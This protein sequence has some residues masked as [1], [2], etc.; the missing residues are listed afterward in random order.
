MPDALAIRDLHVQ[1]HTRRGI[2]KALNGVDLALRRG[3]VLG[4]AGESG[5]GKT[6]LGLAVISLLPRNAAIASGQVVF[7]N[8]DLVNLSRE[9]AE[10]A[11]DRFRPRK[12]ERVLRRVGKAMTQIRGRRISMVFQEPM[13]SLNPVL[14]IGF[15]VAEAV[16]VHDPALLARRVLAREKA[17]SQD[18]RDLLTLLQLTHGDEAAVKKF[19]TDRGLVGIEEQVLHIW[20]RQDIHIS[21]KEKAIRALGGQPMNLFERY[22]FE[23]VVKTGAVP[24]QFSRLRLFYWLVRLSLVG[25]IL[26]FLGRQARRI[27]IKEGYRKAQEVLTSLGIHHAERVVKMYPHEL[28]GGMRQRVVIAIALANNP[29]IVIMDEPTSAVDVTVQAQIL[30]LVKQIRTSVS[31]SFI[32]I[33]HDLAVLAE[34]S[35]RIAIMYAGRIVEVAPT[36]EILQKPLHPYTQQLISAI[37]TLE[38]KSVEGIKGEVP[39]MRDP[40]S[41]CAFHPRC[42]FAFEKCNS[43]V[44]VDFQQGTDQ[45]VACWLYEGK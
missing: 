38:G 11:G 29:E 4:I 30:E 40:P 23:R 9:Y 45:L 31:A 21:R 15:Q 7:D 16:Y 10:R 33:S 26:V 34:V 13:T 24:W 22:V 35:D 12:H 1:F 3:E 8:K 36:A 20:R 42:P 17:T 28:S 44:P 14:S 6:T 27:L 39:D 43:V 37:P 19:A 18:I 25:L 2:Y 41:G 32:V 5:C